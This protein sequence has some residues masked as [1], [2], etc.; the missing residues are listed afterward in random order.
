M[1]MMCV[2]EFTDDLNDFAEHADEP[3]LTT[4]VSSIDTVT[5]A[6]VLLHGQGEG[7][8]ARPSAVTRG[9]STAS[10]G[11]A[12]ALYT[13]PESAAV[14]VRNA[15]YRGTATAPALRDSVGVANALYTPSNTRRRT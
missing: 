15:M 10:V 11:V 8:A 1:M 12:N 6:A 2:K 14:A 9:D 5:A 13:P 4:S 7:D 3:T